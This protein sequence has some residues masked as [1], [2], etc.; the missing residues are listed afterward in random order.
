MGGKLEVAADDEN[1]SLDGARMKVVLF[2]N[3]NVPS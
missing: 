3:P 1:H 2:R